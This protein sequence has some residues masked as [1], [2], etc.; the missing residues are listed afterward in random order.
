MHWSRAFL[1]GFV[2]ALAAAAQPTLPNGLQLVR[3]EVRAPEPAVAGGTVTVEFTL[4]NESSAPM[5]FDPEVGIFVGARVN[6]TSNENN[7]DFGHGQK[8]LVLAPGREV[9]VRAARMLDAAGTWR[10][11]P[12]FRMNGQWG[13]FRWM[14]K[15]VEVY[16][17]A[18]Q[19]KQAGGSGPV[20]GTLT[21][22][23]LLRN[24]SA[25][26][27]KRVT[28]RG[29]A[30]AVRRRTDPSSGP[31][32]LMSMVDIEDKRMVM[33]VIS[34]GQAPVVNGDVAIA[35]GVFRMKSP[36]GRYTYD[37]ELICQAG[38]IVKDQRAS[39][40][41]LA[42]EKSDSRPIIDVRR[43][44]GRQ[45]DLGLLKGRVYATGAE[46]PVQF[47]TRT[48]SQTPR[49]NTIVAT[50]RGT[51]GIRLEAAE[52]RQQWGGP[53]T[54]PAGSG[55]TWL[56]L[57]LWL[58][59]NASNAGMPETFTQSFYYFDP[60]PVFFVVDRAGSVYWPDGLVSSPITYQHKGD[61]TMSDVRMN[62]PAWVR[63]G[64][65]FKVPQ[66]IQDPIL[67]I[68][69]YLGPNRFEYAGIRL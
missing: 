46:V 25:Y 12:A 4:K 26:D 35:T 63:S 43:T 53:G 15:T 61:K 50:G 14:E 5:R 7:R 59:G 31:W 48:Y 3:F 16:A 60:G 11:W 47:Q 17:S 8:G 55:L 49:R 2:A 9:S 24:P 21:V 40:Q 36:R 58:R 57:R 1:I 68:M 45:F 62:D 69:T 67:V 33:N 44:V 37:N 42:D 34:P 65:A 32:T 20:A 64:L 10:F 13:P 28:V 19:A 51:A 39:E 52:R 6:S 29:D 66:A 56:I 41:K 30:L 18:A 38:G 23:Q 54:D 27:G 22:A